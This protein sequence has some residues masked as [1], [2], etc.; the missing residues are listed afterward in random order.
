[1]A[2]KKKIGDIGRMQEW[3][4]DN[5]D[6][7]FNEEDEEILPYPLIPKKISCFQRA[8]TYEIKNTIVFEKAIEMF[9]IPDDGY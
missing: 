6:F 8:L 1:M 2:K 7:G 9:G 5:W 3:F 4:E